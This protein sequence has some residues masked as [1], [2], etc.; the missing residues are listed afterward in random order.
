MFDYLPINQSI[1]HL[2]FCLHSLC[3]PF[4]VFPQIQFIQS[5]LPFYNLTD[6]LHAVLKGRHILQRAVHDSFPKPDGWLR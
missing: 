2:H 6:F 4:H 5:I 3:Q 1:R